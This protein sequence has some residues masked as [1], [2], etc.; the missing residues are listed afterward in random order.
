MN[1]VM[2]VNEAKECRFIK[3]GVSGYP[4]NMRDFIHVYIYWKSFYHPKT[5]YLLTLSIYPKKPCII[6][7]KVSLKQNGEHRTYTASYLCTYMRLIIKN[8]HRNL[9]NTV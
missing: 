4:R 2:I 8:V 7:A 9:T 3:S 5:E 1:Y 6:Y